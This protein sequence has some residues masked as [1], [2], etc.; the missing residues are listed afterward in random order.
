M[1]RLNRGRRR[2]GVGETAFQELL[3]LGLQSPD[4]DPNPSLDKEHQSTRH[5]NH[6]DLLHQRDLNLPLKQAPRHY[7]NPP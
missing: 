2:V 1:P 6:R 7:P 5:P 3:P 4:Q